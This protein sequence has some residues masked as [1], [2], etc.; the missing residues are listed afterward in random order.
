MNHG[1][2]H[3]MLCSVS[4]RCLWSSYHMAVNLRPLFVNRYQ[5]WKD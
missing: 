3:S 2:R 4:K 5:F 1:Y